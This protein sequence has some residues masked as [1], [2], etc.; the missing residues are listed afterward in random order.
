MALLMLA[1]LIVFAVLAITWSTTT[2]AS[3]QSHQELL[4]MGEAGSEGDWWITPAHVR[5]WWFGANAASEEGRATR[6]RP[7]DHEVLPARLMQKPAPTPK[8]SQRAGFSNAGAQSTLDT[9]MAGLEPGRAVIDGEVDRV[10]TL[11]DELR[12]FGEDVEAARAWARW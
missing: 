1:A 8:R 2:A 9:L 3:R 6:H 10:E 4:A 12:R 11:S 7:H 5:M